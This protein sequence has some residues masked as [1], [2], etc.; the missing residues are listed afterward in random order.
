MGWH[1]DNNKEIFNNEQLIKIFS[2]KRIQK[3]NA[4]FDIKK[5]DWMNS[6]YIKNLDVNVLINLSHDFIEND[7]DLSDNDKLIKA[8]SFIKNRITTLQDISDLLYP[9]YKNVVISDKEILDCINKET[10]QNIIK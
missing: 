3:S 2:I 5:L 4:I 6:Q 1:P 8:F 9:F 10:S 7:F